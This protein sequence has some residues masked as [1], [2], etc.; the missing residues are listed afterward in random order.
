MPEV[1][2]EGSAGMRAAVVGHVE[3]VTF[4]RVERLPVA[5]E[6]LHALE[7]WEA[8][9]G[10]G[11]VAAAQLARL[12]GGAT[13][14]TALGNDPL[15][16]RARRDLSGKLGLRVEAAARREPTRRAVTHL[17]GAGERS[18]TV[19]GDRLAP[20]ADDPLPWDELARADVVYLCAGDAGAVRAARRA[21]VL[22]ATARVLPILREAGVEL[23][24]VVGSA[25]DPAERFDPTEL[26]PRPRLS[27][28]TSGAKGGTFRPRG[29]RTR[30]YTPSPVPGPIA[31][32]YGCGDAFAAGLA[33]ALAEGQDPEAAV[34]FAA[35]CGAALLATRGPY[36]E[37]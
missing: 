11:P 25:R 23:D 24:A 19:L 8:P 33:Y 29:G 13:L 35:R 12:A 15:G 20:R 17:D 37:A 30:M 27:V 36:P 3:W 22:V 34:A 2:V 10:G 21:R 26:R 31:D 28:W 14:Y 4:L 18:I 32:S 1:A 5:G 16:R 6:I 7:A 9:A